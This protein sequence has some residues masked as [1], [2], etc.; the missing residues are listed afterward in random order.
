MQRRNYFM[1]KLVSPQKA[2]RKNAKPGREIR[3]EK[4]VKNLR[5]Q[6]KMIR[7]KKDAGTCRDKK[8]KATQGKITIQLEEI[9]QKVLAKEGRLKRYRQRVKQNKQNS[10]RKF[11]QQMGG[12]DTKTYQPLDASETEQCWTKIWQTRE[13]YKKAEWISNITKELEGL[14]EGPKAEI[15]IYLFKTTLKKISNWKTQRPRWIL[16]KKKLTSILDRL[17]LEMN[18]CL[19]ETH[20]P[21]WMTKGKIPLIQKNPSKEPPQTTTD[22]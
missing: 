21:E 8:E 15:H 14:E 17:A 4:Q 5:K 3:L 6:A 13:H 19:Q 10:E 18:R 1:R 7:Q 11:Y 12:D 20:I 16:V 22:P 2:Q 9:N